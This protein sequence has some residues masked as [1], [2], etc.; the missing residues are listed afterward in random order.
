VPAERLTEAW[1]RRRAFAQGVSDELLRAPAATQPERARR[2][3]R[4]LVRGG[5]AAPILARRLAERRGSADARIW[6]SY[7]RGRI[8]GVRGE[9]MA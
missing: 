3:A 6:L 5:R 9:G 7:C 1:F 4:E 2:I 8:A